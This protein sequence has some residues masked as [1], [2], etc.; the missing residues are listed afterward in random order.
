MRTLLLLAAL[1]SLTPGCSTEDTEV[2][3]ITVLA[4]LTPCRRLEVFDCMVVDEGRG[5][6]DLFENIEGFVYGWGSTYRLEVDITEIR[7]PPPDGD[8]RELRLR[9]VI[10][11]QQI[12]PRA[13]FTLVLRGETNPGP[14]VLL[15]PAGQGFAMPG[16]RQIVC[17][18]PTVCAAIPGALTRPAAFDLSLRHPDDPT[19]ERAPLTA[20]GVVLR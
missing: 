18:D 2:A 7:H 6:S 20:L 15:I 5:P 19:D 11:V 1:A 16:G 10:D 4:H 17:D 9:Q 14:R 3:E 8:S 12:A 13:E